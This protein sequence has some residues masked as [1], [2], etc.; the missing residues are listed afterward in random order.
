[1]SRPPRTGRAFLAAALVA[2]GAAAVVAAVWLITDVQGISFRTVAADPVIVGDGPV[3]AG[4]FSNMGVL[5][6]WSGATAAVLLGALL[7]R[8]GDARAGRAMLVLGAITAVLAADDLFLLHEQ[9]G[10][11]VLGIAQDTILAGYAL[12]IVVVLVALRQFLLA[13]A[14]PILALSLFAFAVSVVSDLLAD[15]E[16]STQSV[17]E[18]GAKF[19][20]IA[21][22]TVFLVQAGW[23]RLRPEAAA[24][25]AAPST[26]AAEPARR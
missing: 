7:L 23:S 16:T 15:E 21:A 14:W 20:G 5:V 2:V 6:W 19:V 8:Q 11:N 10:P 22:W 24:P 13:S 9:F 3:H 18:D 4:V 25:D 17:I 12:G 26:Q 1:M